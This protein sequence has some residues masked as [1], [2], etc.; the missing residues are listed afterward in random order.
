MRPALNL[1]HLDIQF[2]NGVIL[3]LLAF[4]ADVDQLH[5]VF[6]LFHLLLYASLHASLWLFIITFLVEH[7]YL[8]DLVIRIDVILVK[9]LKLFALVSTFISLVLR[10]VDDVSDEAR[11]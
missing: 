10:Y 1:G 11:T 7:G 8:H 2:V 4:F 3:L 9:R 6:I 5:R